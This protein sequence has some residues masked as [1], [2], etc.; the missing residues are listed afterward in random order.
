MTL[1]NVN[2]YGLDSVFHLGVPNVLDGTYG[3]IILM[4]IMNHNYNI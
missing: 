1:V 4:T 3:Q 2:F